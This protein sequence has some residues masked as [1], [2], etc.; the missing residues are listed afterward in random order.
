M[1]WAKKQSGFTI[2]ELLIV[3]VVIAILA[4]ITI[5]SYNAITD[6]TKQSAAQSLVEQVNKKILA[7]A[8]VNGETY[9]P[10]LDAIGISASD[11][12]N[13][14]YSVNYSASPPTYG[15][16]ATNGKYSYYT[17]ST[18]SQPTSGGYPGHS[19][20][21]VA[22]I[23]NMSTNPSVENDTSGFSGANGSTISRQSAAAIFGSNGLRVVTPSG[24][25]TDSG[26]RI[27]YLSGLN[28]GQKF[29]I[30]VSVR[31]VTAGT[32]RLSLQ[33]TSAGGSSG[34]SQ[35]ITLSANQVGRITY[36][37]TT[38]AAGDITGY[39]L[40]T[41]TATSTFDID[42]V[43]IIQG[44]VTS[45]YADGDTSGWVWNGNAG[46]STSKGVPI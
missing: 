8:V 31:A 12:A 42:G 44:D 23:T 40:R 5:V 13:L 29:T 37:M 45:G 30:S 22:A 1:Q 7:Y 32:Y 18:V 38:A 16:T 6:R 43:M 39:I 41:N 36:L 46:N 20:N 35:P 25:V 2:V 10:D 17:S 19:A 24:G 14:Q 34:F 4:A 21:G 26:V 15:L 11:Q 33:G 27:A 28:S 9:P 3:V